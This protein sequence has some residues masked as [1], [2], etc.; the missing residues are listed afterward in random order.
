MCPVRFVTYVSGRS[1]Q[2][3]LVGRQLLVLNLG[4]GALYQFCTTNWVAKHRLVLCQAFAK[5]ACVFASERLR[6]LTLNQRVPGSSNQR[7]P[8]SSPG[9]PTTRKLLKDRSFFNSFQHFPGQTKSR[10]V[11]PRPWALST[12]YAGWL[13]A[14]TSA[15]V[16][17]LPH[18]ASVARRAAR[19]ASYKGHNSSS[20]TNRSWPLRRWRMILLVL[21]EDRTEGF[22]WPEFRS[23]DFL[24]TGSIPV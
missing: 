8:G 12:Y 23:A 22:L 24:Q 2:V 3:Q 14:R 11:V 10:V 4:F 9:A 18:V 20:L 1:E 21:S 19:E 7:V 17:K 6:P 16:R 5:P 15:S 13:V